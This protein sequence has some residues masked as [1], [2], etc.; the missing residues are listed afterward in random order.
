MHAVL[1]RLI[2]GMFFTMALEDYYIDHYCKI[3]ANNY[4][5]EKSGLLKHPR[6]L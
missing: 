5:D 3:K 2:F 6:V 4:L 1:T